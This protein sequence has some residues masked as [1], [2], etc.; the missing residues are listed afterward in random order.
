LNPI[1]DT[2]QYKVEFPDDSSDPFGANVIAESMYSQIDDKGHSFQILKEIIDHKSDGNPVSL[3][4]GFTKEP[5]GAQNP[6][7]TTKGWKLL[8]QWKDGTSSWIPLKDLKESNLVETAEY[9][10]ANKIMGEP[11]FARWICTVLRQQDRIIKKVKACAIGAKRTNIVLS[12][13]RESKQ[14]SR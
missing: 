10:V 1:L 8:V 14:P 4:D 13:P 7:R 5:D 11:A 12:F 2:R 3:D 9:A 6:Q